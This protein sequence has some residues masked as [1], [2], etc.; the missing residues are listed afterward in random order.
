MVTRVRRSSPGPHLR[1]RP[2]RTL[3]E[4]PRPHHGR[5]Y[6]RCRRCG[7][8]RR[9]HT[10]LQ[11]RPEGGF[12]QAPTARQLLVDHTPEEPRGCTDA[13]TCVQTSSLSRDRQHSPTLL[14]GDPPHGPKPRRQRGPRV[15]DVKPLC[16][17]ENA[18]LIKRCPKSAIEARKQGLR[19]VRTKSG[20]MVPRTVRLRWIRWIYRECDL[21]RAAREVVD[22]VFSSSTPMVTTR[23]SR[24]SCSRSSTC[25]TRGRRSR[26]LVV[27]LRL[28]SFRDFPISSSM[29]GMLNSV[30]F[31]SRTTRARRNGER[32]ADAFCPVARS[33]VFGPFV[34]IWCKRYGGPFSGSRFDNFPHRLLRIGFSSANIKGHLMP[35]FPWSAGASLGAA[36]RCGCQ[37]GCQTRLRAGALD[38]EVS[39]FL[40]KSGEPPRNRTGNLQIKSLLL[41]QLS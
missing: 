9:A 4:T 8:T 39:V 38:Q 22:L 23:R 33:T 25:R 34:T 28:G 17:S 5:G 14:V 21:R 36:E 12:A 37:L 32:D 2:T 30:E 1:L 15:L 6:G 29:Y 40:A 31:P 27:L 10:C 13:T 16:G 3:S 20:Q 24:L 7:R 26:S 19:T 18:I 11:N 35:L 41:C